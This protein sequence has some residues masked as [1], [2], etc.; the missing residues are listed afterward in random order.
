[1]DTHTHEPIRLSETETELLTRALLEAQGQA[2]L[3]AAQET[4]TQMIRRADP[5]A[6]G[7]VGDTQQTT[8]EGGAGNM[9]F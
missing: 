8:R 2:E 6:K 4:E 5:G 3:P 7:K 9:V 1:M